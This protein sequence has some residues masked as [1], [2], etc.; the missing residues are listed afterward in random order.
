MASKGPE[1][2]STYDELFRERE[3]ERQRD[4]KNFFGDKI[5]PF[6][7]KKSWNLR[8]DIAVIHNFFSNGQWVISNVVINITKFSVAW[9]LPKRTGRLSSD[10][11][12]H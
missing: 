9:T 1:S 7:A 5:C 4:L 2:Y 6:Q 11:Q 8:D 12:R 3:R 10:H